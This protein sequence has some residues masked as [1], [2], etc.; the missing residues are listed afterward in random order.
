MNLLA[1]ATSALLLPAAAL[2]L[3]WALG[4]WIPIRNEAQLARAVVGARGITRMPGAV[5]C[6]LV[7]VALFFAALLP[8]L[9]WFPYR[10]LL[11]SS[12]AMVFLLRGAAAYLPIWRAMVPEQ[13]F[14][15]LDT[16]L[17][18]PLC[19]IIGA[20]LLILTVQGY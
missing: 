12:F 17:Y 1:F 16:R 11:L 15:T 9:S 19:L 6:A 14:A 8:H 5:P 4:F 3:L 13:P 20:S 7:A 2:H 18:G 10:H